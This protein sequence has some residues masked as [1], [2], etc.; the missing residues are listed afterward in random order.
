MCNDNGT[1]KLF[2]KS[3]INFV[4]ICILEFIIGI[5]PHF[6]NYKM[7]MDINHYNFQTIIAFIFSNLLS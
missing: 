4:I 2:K 1:Y 5:R 6:K 3:N 7:L